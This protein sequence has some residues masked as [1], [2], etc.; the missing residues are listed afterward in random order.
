MQ[1]RFNDIRVKVKAGPHRVGVAFMQR[2]F[3]QSDSPLQPIA[4]LPEMERYPTIPGI[5]IS[6]PSI[7]PAWAKPRAAGASSCAGPTSPS[8][9][10]ALRARAFCRSLAQRSVP[11]AGDGRGSEGAA[12]VLAMGRQAAAASKP[13]S[14]AGSP[15]F[16]R[17]RNSC[18]ARSQPSRTRRPGDPCRASRIWSSPRAS[19][20]SSGV[21]V[22]TNS[23]S[24]SPL[25][26]ACVTPRCM[27]AQMR[28]MLAD[29]R[30]ESLV[31][32]FAFQWLNV[33]R[34][35]NIQPDPVLYPDFDPDLRKGFREE[36]RLFLGS[37]LR[38][39]RSV[40]DLLRS[41]RHFPERAARRA[42][43]RCRTFAARSSG[44]C[45]SRT[46]IAGVC[47]ARARC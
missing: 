41:D 17:A 23:S 20:S 8:R 24:S 11:P 46:R 40:L 44:R 16:C 10:A 38:S 36:I 35:D 33:G 27:N 34:I 37:V 43:R 13:A 25:P 28:R 18:S 7:R 1:A 45:S 39:N 32:N 31:T 12:R 2:S 42:L 29:P 9:R 26:A 4:M 5:D 6:G 15:P 22:R 47:S 19:R 21:P 14:K 3:A 30:S